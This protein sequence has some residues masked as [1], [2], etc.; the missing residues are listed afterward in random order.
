M[1]QLLKNVQI[2]MSSWLGERVSAVASWGC[3]YG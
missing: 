3:Q 2:A 1:E